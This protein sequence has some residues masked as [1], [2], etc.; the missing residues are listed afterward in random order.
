MKMLAVPLM[1]AG[2]GMASWI[3]ATAWA[4]T[5]Q[6]SA[7]LAIGDG[8]V[9]KGDLNGRDLPLAKALEALP[10]T[11]GRINILPGSYEVSQ[12]ATVSIPNVTI[13][14]LGNSTQIVVKSQEGTVDFVLAD[15]N[16]SGFCI[17][18]CAFAWSPADGERA[19]VACK[20]SNSRVQ[21]CSFSLGESGKREGWASFITFGAKEG[22]I[23]G[24]WVTND[25]FTLGDW[26]RGVRI[27]RAVGVHV[28]GN[29][30]EGQ[31]GEPSQG[32]YVR[33]CNQQQYVGNS[34][35]AFGK[36]NGPHASY[37]IL[38]DNVAGDM[39][40]LEM[41]GNHLHTFFGT[42]TCAVKCVRTVYASITGNVVGRC[43]G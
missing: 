17:E 11:G 21:D 2:V 13:S 10:P 1:I 25:M 22:A 37:G 33:D 39:G 15:E 6:G 19:L 41:A 34:I 23:Q 12:C 20:G 42:G 26:C 35:N 18:D 30:F 14:G 38:I 5:P 28:V 4:G 7:L 3:W 16:A 36:R 9:S 40:H 8:T 32:V 43:Q 31:L 27:E 29:R 24:L